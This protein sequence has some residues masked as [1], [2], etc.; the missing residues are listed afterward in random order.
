MDKNKKLYLATRGVEA[1]F[2]LQAMCGQ[3]ESKASA[4]AKWRR[5]SRGEQGRMI[6]A[7]KLMQQLAAAL[8]KRAR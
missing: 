6:A 1:I 3:K 5:L 8:L 4:T 2:S 7:H